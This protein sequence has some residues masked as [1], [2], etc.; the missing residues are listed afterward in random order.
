MGRRS[1]VD[2][3]GLH[4]GNVRK[5]GEEFEVIDELLRSLCTAFDLEGKDGAAAVREVFLVESLLFRIIRYGRM[6]YFFYE[7]MVV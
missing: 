5:Q 3:E 6:V 1:R 7:R 4:V 2:H